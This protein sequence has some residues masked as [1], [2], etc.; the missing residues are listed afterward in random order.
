[1]DVD[2]C[3]ALSTDLEDDAKVRI[4]KLAPHE[5]VVAAQGLLACDGEHD[6]CAELLSCWIR[7]LSDASVSDREVRLGEHGHISADEL[8]ILVQFLAKVTP[9]NDVI[10]RTICEL[11]EE[12]A[13]ELTESGEAHIAS[14]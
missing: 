8:A 11:L 7:L 4:P 3:K 14:S 1:M 13:G 6:V 12:V 2:H 5:L 10:F 9:E